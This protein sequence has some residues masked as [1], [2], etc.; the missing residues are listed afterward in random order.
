VKTNKL[1]ITGKHAAYEALMYAPHAVKRVYIARGFQ[2]N[3]INKLIAQAGLQKEPLQEGESRAD[4]KGNSSSQGIVLQISLI[5]MM[6]PLEK[7]IDTLKVSPSTSLL[8]LSG[9]QDPHN[10]GAIIRSA[11]AFGATAVLMPQEKQSPITAAVIKSSAGMA[12]Q[13]PLVTIPSIQTAL[14]MLKKR[15]FKAYALAAGRQ[16]ISGAEFAS[17]CVFVLGNEGQGI[18]KAMRALCDETLSIP[19]HLRAESLNVAA[20][21]AV[22]LHA[23]S[24]KH[25]EALK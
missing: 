14:A 12:F 11:A 2:D 1:Y 15:G 10:A 4:V 22:A 8:L 17:P 19:M 16:N 20:S 21:A 7:F 5:D 25:P 9:V 13:L 3:N 23:W 24:Q 18:D 6:Q